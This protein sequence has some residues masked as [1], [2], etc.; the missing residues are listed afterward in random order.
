MIIIW[1]SYAVST[2]I[3]ILSLA[4]G[5]FAFAYTFTL[6]RWRRAKIDA[7]LPKAAVVLSLR[8]SEP[9][10]YK[11]MLAILEQDYPDFSLVSRIYW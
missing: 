10:L 3:L 2:G 6:L 8:G 1:I 9:F 7:E 11:N 5:A 4:Q